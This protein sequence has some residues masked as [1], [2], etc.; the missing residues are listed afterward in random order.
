[1]RFSAR[2]RAVLAFVEGRCLADIGTD[3]GYLPIAACLEGLVEQAIAC[4]VSAGSLEKAREN[5]RQFGLEDRIK[6][7]LGYGL[8]A[9]QEEDADCVVMSGIG[10]MNIIEILKDPYINQVK[11][12]VLQPQRDIEALRTA[13]DEKGFYII[14]EATVQDRGRSYT[15]IAAGR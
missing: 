9:L 8:Q 13:L 6:T 7:R 15:V 3:H 10:G 2:L 5:I 1:M 12:L 4:D 14:N 11:R